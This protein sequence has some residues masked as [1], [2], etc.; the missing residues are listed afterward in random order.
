MFWRLRFKEVGF[1]IK[2]FGNDALKVRHPRG[3]LAGIQNVPLRKNYAV[4]FAR[5]IRSESKPTMTVVEEPMNVY[6]VH[7]IGVNKKM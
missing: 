1:P 5:K 7:A 6:H 2:T 4:G 3:F